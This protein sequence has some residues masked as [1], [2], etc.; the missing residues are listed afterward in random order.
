MRPNTRR[1]GFKY[2]EY[3]LVYVDDLL[4]VSHESKVTMAK[5]GEY[6]NLKERS[7][8]EPEEYLGS[9]IRKYTLAPSNGDSAE[10]CWSMS[11]DT[12]VKRTVV[13][14]SPTL[15]EVGQRLRKKVST[16]LSTA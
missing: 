3:I 10:F 4:V 1:D 5:L 6:Y 9:D 16:P 14:V 13:D 7:V 2:W 11:A 8:R 15:D 12:Y